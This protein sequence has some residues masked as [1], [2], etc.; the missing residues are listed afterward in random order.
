MTQTKIIVKIWI[1]GYKFKNPERKTLGR[2]ARSLE[3]LTSL[4]PLLD[5]F[6][7]IDWRKVKE[8]LVGL[9]PL[10]VRV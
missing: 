9:E 8:Q 3:P 6:R 2:A 5:A 10:L 7:T 1:Y 4:L